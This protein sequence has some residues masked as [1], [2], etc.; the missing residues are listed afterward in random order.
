MEFLLSV[1]I[2]LSEENGDGIPFEVLSGI[3]VAAGVLLIVGVVI[4]L[5]IKKRR[6]NNETKMDKLINQTF[7]Q[8]NNQP[9]EPLNQPIIPTVKPTVSPAVNQ[10]Q[11]AA[12]GRFSQF[13][14]FNG[15]KEKM[16]PQLEQ[17]LSAHNFIPMLYG[18]ETGMYGQGI[19]CVLVRNYIK[20][21]PQEA[22]FL[23]EAFIFSHGKELNFEC[24]IDEVR[25]KE[26]KEVAELIV[27]A[28]KGAI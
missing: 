13:I 22:G 1:I 25:R 5:V 20:I 12:K 10:P 17:I 27:E 18:E 26:M 4:Y 16:Q 14:L 24:F 28:I 6:V 15:D 9:A 19:G 7:H 21:L 11:T 8:G 3:L 2:G 23:I